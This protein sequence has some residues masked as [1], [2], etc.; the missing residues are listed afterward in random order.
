LFIHSCVCV[1]VGMCS[2]L[3]R[4]WLVRLRPCLKRRC[5]RKVTDDEVSEG[6]RPQPNDY[7][8]EY[9]KP[10]LGDFTLAEYTEKVI[11]YGFVMVHARVCHYITLVTTYST[12]TLSKQG[13]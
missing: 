9:S 10:D 13:S 4:Q 2:F 11:L 6:P 12:L 5:S 8:I 3:K 1:C 7:D